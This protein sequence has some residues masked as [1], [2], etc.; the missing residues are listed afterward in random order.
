MDQDA[1]RARIGE[2]YAA[3]VLGQPLGAPRK[4]AANFVSAT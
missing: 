2:L 3:E 1:Y 4:R